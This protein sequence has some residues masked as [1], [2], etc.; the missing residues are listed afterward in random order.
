MDTSL[1]DSDQFA[2]NTLKGLIMDTVRNANSGHTGGPLSSL[3]FVYILYKEF[4]KFDPNDPE[5][6]DRDRFIM[7]CGHESALIYS[8]LVMV[9]WLEIEDLKN[10]RQLHSKTPGHPEKGITPGVEATTGPL[11]QGVGNAVGMAVAEAILRETYGEQHIN[12]YTYFLHSDG[13]IQEPVAIGSIAM[14][15]HWGLSKLIGYYDAN[16]IQI[17]GDVSRSDSTDYVKLYESHGWHVQEVDGNNRDEIRAAIRR[18]QMEISKPSIIIGHGV[19]ASGCFSME[20]LSDTH[21][22]PLPEEEIY[23]T[24]KNL[25]L[26]PNKQFNLPNEII[27]EFRKGFNYFEREVE[28]WNNALKK[29]QQNSEFLRKWN[30]SFGSELPKIDIPFYESGQKI[31]TRKIWGQIIE[32]I[33]A[34]HPTFVGGSADLE[35]SNVTEGFAKYVGDFL[36]SNQKG[37]NFAFGVRE[38]PMGV[39]LNGI[40]LHGGLKSFG[41]TFFVFS[42]Y[43]RPALRLRALQNLAVV[44][45]Y[46]H[47]SF[48]VGEDGPTHQPI[49]HAMA[50]RCMPNINVMRPAD[51]NEA[52][53]LIKYAFEQNNI[54]SVVLLSRQSIPIIDRDIYS[55]ASSVLKGGY[56]IADEKNPDIIIFATGSEV[57]LALEV[58]KI[59]NEKTVKI[60]NLA[61]WEI[62][63]KQPED[64][65]IKV[66]GDDSVFKVSL[67]AGVTFGWEK[68]TGRN[69]LNIGI[70][71]FGDSAPGKELAKYY[72]FTPEKVADNIKKAIRKIKNQS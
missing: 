39:V 6:I 68:Y 62:F 16:K 69:G 28:S 52:A 26:N 59:I 46:T 4:L 58:K 38:F 42:D 22:A 40:M 21:G 55:P 61:C 57:N 45:E 56:V 34:A 25:G 7:S 44:S 12:H 48:W 30:I 41:A 29:A 31:A 71:T 72:G 43:E 11:G 35:P 24:K 49:E 10:F 53:I 5:W 3:N 47:D 37:R 14:A 65:K 54:P 27:D 20:G 13:D 32:L 50:L 8:M 2:I 33:A 67:E 9:G 23:K 15:G 18:A 64:Y 19:I 66:L 63:E 60:V 70:N 51:A 17:S 1:K 36:N